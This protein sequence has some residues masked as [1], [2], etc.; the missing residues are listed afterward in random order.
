ML[1]QP[2]ASLHQPLLQ[3]GQRPVFKPWQLAA[4][5]AGRASQNPIRRSR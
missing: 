2:A 3:A 1:D 5:G 4:S